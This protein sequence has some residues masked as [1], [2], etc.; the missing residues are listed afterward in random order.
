MPDLAHDFVSTTPENFE[1]LL[2]AIQKRGCKVIAMRD[3]LEYDLSGSGTTAT[4]RPDDTQ[5]E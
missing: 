4:A 1:K 2:R 5:P 3:L